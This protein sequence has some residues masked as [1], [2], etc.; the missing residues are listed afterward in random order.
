GQPSHSRPP[1][2]LTVLTLPPP[3]A[4]GEDAVDR[5]GRAPAGG[6]P[7]RRLGL[8]VA[9]DCPAARC[10]GPRHG[11]A[12]R[13]TDR[14]RLRPDHRVRLPGTPAARAGEQGPRRRGPG[15]LIP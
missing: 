10:P 5:A 8:L 15:P 9:V 1:P 2:R 4:D 3:D 11:V 14:R 6:R 12:A 13:R 7:A